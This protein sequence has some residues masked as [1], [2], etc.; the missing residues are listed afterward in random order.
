V[1]FLTGFFTSCF[2]HNMP[3]F[4]YSVVKEPRIN[5]L[6]IRSFVTLPP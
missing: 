2:L 6:P 1:E 3:P 4:G 5:L